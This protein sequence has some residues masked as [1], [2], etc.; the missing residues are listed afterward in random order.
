MQ[1][2][3][4]TTLSRGWMEDAQFAWLLVRRRNKSYSRWT[5]YWSQRRCCSYRNEWKSK[6]MSTDTVQNIEMLR[7][8]L[9]KTLKSMKGRNYRI[10]K[11]LLLEAQLKKKKGGGG[12]WNSSIMSLKSISLVLLRR[13]RKLT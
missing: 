8:D 12:N 1:G 11:A 10:A 13:E 4:S 3:W 5:N 9:I 7:T 2:G 6:Q